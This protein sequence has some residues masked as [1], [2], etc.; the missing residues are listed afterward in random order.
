M[1]SIRH[2]APASTIAIISARSR[3][4]R[5]ARAALFSVALLSGAI[6]CSDDNG[7][8]PV[9]PTE[10]EYVDAVAPEELKREA[11]APEGGPA[12]SASVRP[13]ASLS[14]AAASAPAYTVSKIAF[15]PESRSGLKQEP[16]GDDL[17]IGGN[18]A[19]L[20]IGFN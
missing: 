4:T 13:S 1:N 14:A 2:A 20:S 8:A 7:L 11:D 18:V 5:L 3:D 9:T 10:L 12:L 15:A 6:S 19:G 17:T 16:G